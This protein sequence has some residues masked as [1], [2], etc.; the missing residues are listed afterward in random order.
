MVTDGCTEACAAMPECT[1]CHKRKHPR[2][3]DPGLYA[4]SGYCAHECPGHNQPPHAG[5][6]SER[7]NPKEAAEV[8]EKGESD[9]SNQ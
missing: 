8:S 9:E 2:G 5:R 3:R 4:S 6:C 7:A 1:V